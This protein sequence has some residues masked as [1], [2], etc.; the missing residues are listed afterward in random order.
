[1]HHQHLCIVLMCKLHG[2]VQVDMAS[3]NSAAVLSAVNATDADVIAQPPL[4]PETAALTFADK[5]ELQQ[6]VSSRAADTALAQPA[7]DALCPADYT[8]LHAQQ[9]NIVQP[10]STGPSSASARELEALD[11]AELLSH[12]QSDV[13]PN[14]SI[15]DCE[16]LASWPPVSRAHGTDPAP[17]VFLSLRQHLWIWQH[18]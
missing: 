1:M 6:A 10:C 15:P 3:C 8:T 4:L 13:Q 17:M 11:T 2:A 7:A 5:P 14:G 18:C 9:Q 12:P 16:T